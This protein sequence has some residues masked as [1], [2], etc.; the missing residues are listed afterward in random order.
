MTQ[1]SNVSLRKR[2]SESYGRGGKPL[3]T[4]T[5]FDNQIQP[6]S[7][8]VYI[9]PDDIW[10]WTG[11]TLSTTRLH[12]NTLD[13]QKVTPYRESD[14]RFIVLLK[15]HAFYRMS[16][17]EYFRI[18]LDLCGYLHGV[19]TMARMGFSPHEQAGLLDP[20]WDGVITGEVTVAAFLELTVSWPDNPDFLPPRLGQVTLHQLTEEASPGYRGRYQGDTKGEPAKPATFH[21][22]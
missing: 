7:I 15:P 19:S 16:T 1:L 21:T 11:L 5:P 17:I 9:N 20:G 4:P 6:A 18:P 8:D 10:E 2:L 14:G 22:R 13:W 3:I 12:L